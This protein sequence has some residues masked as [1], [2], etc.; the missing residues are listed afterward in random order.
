MLDDVKKIWRT[1]TGQH[2]PSASSI[3]N[4]PDHIFKL[5]EVDDNDMKLPVV[6]LVV[7]GM[8]VAGFFLNIFM[9]GGMVVWPFIFAVA[10]LLIVNDASDRNGVG[11]PPLQAY[12]L[13]FGIIV[14]LILFVALV[15][16]INPWVV[17]ALTIAAA[18]FVA[19]DWVKRKSKD[20]EYARRRAAGVCVRCCTPVGKALD[21]ECSNCGL[22]VHMERI[23]LA[24]LAK[25]IGMKGG[26][27]NPRATLLGK[28]PGKIDQTAAKLARRREARFAPAAKFGGKRK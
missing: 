15:S 6:W 22:P 24:R 20:R 2:L 10:V 18:I 11:I 21:E 13:F 27:I 17:V 8:A 12:G 23:N 1:F 3:N 19:R 4:D 25:A 9:R 16:T 28:K 14:A 26:N 5:P 7:I